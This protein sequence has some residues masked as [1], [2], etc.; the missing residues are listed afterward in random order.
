[1]FK[2]VALIT[3]LISLPCLSFGMHYVREC[4]RGL[5]DARRA[6]IARD[7]AAMDRALL[8]AIE[9][10][11]VKRVPWPEFILKAGADVNA[12]D[13]YAA[14]LYAVTRPAPRP[15]E[16]VAL[17]LATGVR[18]D[19]RDSYGLT[20]LHNAARRGRLGEAELLLNH[21]AP[22]DAQ[23]TDGE[24]PV[25]V[26]AASGHQNAVVIIEMLLEAQTKNELHP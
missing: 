17:L 12:P 21:G 1:M 3:F 24:T 6:A 9:A 22:A 13:N 14:L 25:H 20:L 18:P 15:A 5:F 10:G 23:N 16:L 11:D 7:R 19:L 4:L 2:K 8:A 26:A